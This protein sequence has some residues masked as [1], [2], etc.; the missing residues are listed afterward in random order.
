MK[1]L[2]KYQLKTFIKSPFVYVLL[3]ITFVSVLSIFATTISFNIRES[4]LITR[5]FLIFIYPNLTT[6]IT[7]FTIIATV[8][9]FYFYK[10]EGLSFIMQSKP[11]SRKKIFLSN[12]LNSF[13]FNAIFSFLVWLIVIIFASLIIVF[14]N[15]PNVSGEFKYLVFFSLGYMLVTLLLNLFFISVVALCSTKLGR[16]STSGL[17]FGSYFGFMFF[18][19]I[20][21]TISFG[22]SDIFIKEHA[23]N[24]VTKN[25]KIVN[26]FNVEKKNSYGGQKVSA[27]LSDEKIKNNFY[28]HFLNF[29]YIFNIKG[30]IDSSFNSI[31][32]LSLSD[33]EET[34]LIPTSIQVKYYKNLTKDEF[35]NRYFNYYSLGGTNNSV[36][37][38][39]DLGNNNG[40]N[41]Y[42]TIDFLNKA[43]TY[44]IVL[45]KI[46]DT[47]TNN[48]IKKDYLFY[49]R[50]FK[51]KETSSND[52]KFNINELI[53]LTDDEQ[54][55]LKEID[56]KIKPYLNPEKINSIPNALIEQLNILQDSIINRIS[57]NFEK[58]VQN[59]V[60]I[61]WEGWEEKVN[62]FIEELKSEY[63][64]ELPENIASVK[65]SYL[66]KKLMWELFSMKLQ[67]QTKAKINDSSTILYGLLLKYF[68]ED[69]KKYSYEVYPNKLI[70][71]DVFSR[72]Y[73]NK[74]YVGELVT[75]KYPLYLSL[76]IIILLSSGSYSLAY[77]LNKK[78]V[79][80]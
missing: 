30:M 58:E 47:K 12:S 41:Y 2:F 5:S 65:A 46:E 9:S 19:A 54:T 80:N 48:N 16:K 71:S 40:L 21:G 20:I 67:A 14:K 56:D 57:I 7:I 22:V 79:I 29:L 51:I 18:N 73:S 68:D 75:W 69:S 15:N 72:Q 13:I 23:E 44:E 45:P 28:S 43:R 10:T 70:S 35:E 63:P 42:K 76:L 4:G 27:L 77:F 62:T 38:F 17:V 6:L 61:N 55:K 50:A 8:F 66:D 1:T 52:S 36:K 64:D 49:S 34:H 3:A 24:Y 32:S 39:I 31:S 33:Y 60:K 26:Y 25:G 53:K 59:R 78:R 11:I 74:P 37:S